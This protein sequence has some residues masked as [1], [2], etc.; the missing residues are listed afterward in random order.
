VCVFCQ[1][2][3][4]RFTLVAVEVGSKGAR[5]HWL[6]EGWTKGRV[7]HRGEGGKA[8][9]KQKPLCSLVDGCW[10]AGRMKHVLCQIF[11]VLHIVNECWEWSKS[12]WCS[13]VRV[14]T[15]LTLNKLI[16]ATRP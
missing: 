1:I 12:C 10:S 11:T 14:G 16:R 7:E 13:Q 3:N 5:K 6:G 9:G 2:S 4:N 8:K 15:S